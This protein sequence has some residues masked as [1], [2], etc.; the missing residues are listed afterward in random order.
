MASKRS[1]TDMQSDSDED[2]EHIRS[3]HLSTNELLQRL[4][5]EQLRAIDTTGLSVRERLQNV[6]AEQRSW[7]DMGDDESIHSDNGFSNHHHHIP[8]IDSDERIMSRHDGNNEQLRCLISEQ[9]N[10][11]DT[12]G[13]SV[14]ERLQNLIAEQRS[15]LDGDD[16]DHETIQSGNGFSNYNHQLPNMGLSQDE[17][18][19]LTTEG[20]RVG[21]FVITPRPRFNGLEIQRTLNLR[22]IDTNDLADF[23][24]RLHNILNEIVHFSQ[25]TAGDTGYVNI[26]LTGDSLP[27]SINAVLTPESNHDP[28]LFIDQIERAAQSNRDVS[29]D[30]SL[31]LRVSVAMD[32]QGGGGA[33]RKITDMAIS[34]TIK[35]NK[36]H[37][38]CPMNLNDNMCLSY[39]LTYFLNPT[40]T[41]QQ[42]QKSAMDIH[43]SCG[44]APH[45]KIGF[46]DL[47]IFERKL[48]LK[49]VVFHRDCTGK[50]QV[51]KNT[52]EIHPKTANLYIHE[53]HYYLI[54]NLKGFLGTSYVCQ[55]CYRGF[56]DRRLHKCKY[57]CNIC[58]TSECR[59]HVTNYKH[60]PDCL[61]YC[62]NTFCYEAHKQERTSVEKSQCDTIKYCTKCQKLYRVARSGDKT[63][64]HKCSPESCVHCNEILTSEGSHECYIQPLKSEMCDEKYIYYDFET[65]YQD[66]KHVANFVCA[67]TQTGETFEAGG[68]DCVARL[69]KHFRRP[70]YND[71]TFIAHNAS[72]FDSYILLQYFSSEGITPKVIMQGCRILHMYD[73]AFRQ[74]Y[75]DS[76]QFLPFSL[77]K[78]PAALNLTV[79]DKGFFPHHFN[80]LENANYVGP[81]PAKELYGYETM[82]EIERVRFDSWYT[83]V[84]NDVFDFEKELA[85]YCRNDVVILREAC[86]KYRKEFIECTNIDPFKS[87]TLAGTCMKVFKTNFLSRDTV[88]L[89]HSHAYINQYKTYSNASIQWLEFIKSKDCVPVQH[90]LN[91]GEQAFG[92]YHVD[93]YYES[94]D[95]VKT[96]LEFLGCFYHGHDC[97]FKPE[98][99]QPLS[100][101][102]FGTLRRQS[103]EKI[104]TLRKVYSLRVITIWECEWDHAKQTNHDVIQFMESYEAPER[105]RP[106]DALFG[107]R[108]NAYKLYHK[109]AD[110]ER[111]D[112]YD[113]TSLYPYVQSS[114]TYPIGHPKIIF[115][116]F[117]EIDN[118]FGLIKATVLPP[119]KLFHPVLPY[120]CGGKLMFPLCRTCA[121]NQIQ[122]PQCSHTD[123]DRSITATWVS[124]EL[125]RAIQHGY[126]VIKIHEV[127]HFSQS[128]DTLFTDYVK[129]FLKSKQVASGFPSHVVTD[130]DKQSYVDDYL[131]KQGVQLDI[132]NIAHNPAKRS[133]SKLILNTL[134]GRFSL[135]TH[136]PTTELLTEPEE[137]TQCLFGG[138]G[139]IIKHF[140]FVS[141]SVAL[142]QWS[143]AERDPCPTRDVNVFIGAFTTAYARLELYNLLDKLGERV[144]YADTDSVIFV[145]KNGD[146][147]PETG[148]YLGQLTSELATGDTVVEF[149]SSGPKSYGFR[150]AN[151]HTCL[152]AKG[153]TLNANNAQIVTLQSLIGLVCAYVE[154]GDTQELFP[155]T[156][157]ITRNKRTFTLHNRSIVKSFRLVY[158]KRVLQP[159]YTTLPYGF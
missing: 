36:M 62:R 28:S 3:R 113:F 122:D 60:C 6:I 87:V 57:V 65:M 137:F 152:K 31:S 9:L 114:K 112:Y 53:S 49:I 25:L 115:E 24:H 46:H 159:D 133:I 101:V 94:V 54:K 32:H 96:A 141:D 111:V 47:N 86:I 78:V 17:I 145:S 98:E 77:K 102:S 37:L 2:V 12:T 155:R 56:N 50:V 104:E 147:I 151:G 149:A 8:N 70:K 7:L 18:H 10:A 30:N 105:L 129:T 45:D 116:D 143:Y 138:A 68:T 124:V 156:E 103:D 95:G 79:N 5:R 40:F 48:N 131:D 121:E 35:R 4:I 107:G 13:L 92:P 83:C 73:A 22:E 34:D 74:R 132:A 108:T 63:K 93:G 109:T 38:F 16:D 76:F 89:T 126:H 110:D 67:M 118:Y 142:I 14:R 119:R 81:Y 117:E 97:R 82:S 52:D 99:I 15:W 69:I 106:R 157:T 29:T 72:G 100:K 33:R 71:Y 61:R 19:T 136:L 51:Y 91:H 39:C 1:Y 66:D 154:T 150:T 64:P 75:V 148:S 158:N 43:T 58:C 125:Q 20:G 84:L 55:F 85:F 88:A 44:F 130:A 59:T 27:T 80:R 23:N 90:A 26:A 41:D 144:L 123:V 134:W 140:S 11:L 139:R 146:W 135:R 42:L 153:I 128:T 127:W 120:R 21:D